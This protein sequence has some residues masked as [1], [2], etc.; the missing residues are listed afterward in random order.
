[1]ILQ[2]LRINGE[3]VVGA[4]NYF[5]RVKKFHSHID[6]YG[7][8]EAFRGLYLLRLGGILKFVYIKPTLNI[9]NRILFN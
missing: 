6:S 1:M 3:G 8:V 2:L 5:C 9:S 4:T 7:L